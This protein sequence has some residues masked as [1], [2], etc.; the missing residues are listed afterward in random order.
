MAIGN[1]TWFDMPTV[2]GLNQRPVHPSFGRVFFNVDGQKML[3]IQYSVLVINIYN[4]V[5]TSLNFALTSHSTVTAHP[6]THI[7][8]QTCKFPIGILPKYLVFQADFNKN[9]KDYVGEVNH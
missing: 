4:R 7:H 9:F 6:C 3:K 1:S 8:E 2:H 5:Y